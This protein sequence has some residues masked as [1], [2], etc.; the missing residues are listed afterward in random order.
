MH[1]IHGIITR[2]TCTHDQMVQEGIKPHACPC[3]PREHVGCILGAQPF[4]KHEPRAHGA[5]PVPVPVGDAL[6]LAP[7]LV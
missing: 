4:R 2:L 7:T 6:G 1:Q 3:C 5:S